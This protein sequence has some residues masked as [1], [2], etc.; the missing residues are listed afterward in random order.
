MTVGGMLF[1]IC[2]RINGMFLS[3]LIAVIK[4]TLVGNGAGNYFGMVMMRHQ[5][6]SQKN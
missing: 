2:A 3:V 6:V 5:V 1:C 4:R